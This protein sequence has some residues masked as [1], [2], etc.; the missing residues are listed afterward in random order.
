MNAHTPPEPILIGYKAI[1]N[2]LGLSERQASWMIEQ[3]RLPI[4]RIG[5]RPCAR[6]ETLRAWVIEQEEKARKE[7]QRTGHGT[8]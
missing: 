5:R 4:F 8:Y 6:P 3:E 7:R 2:F 1:G